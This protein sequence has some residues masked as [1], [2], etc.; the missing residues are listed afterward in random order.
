MKHLY[1]IAVAL[2]VL[3]SVSCKSDQDLIVGKW[4][5]VGYTYPEVLEFMKSGEFRRTHDWGPPQYGAKIRYTICTGTYELSKQRI[6]KWKAQCDDRTTSEQ[7]LFVATL[8]DDILSLEA[9][10]F[11]HFGTALQ[12]TF[13]K[14]R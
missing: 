6:L 1:L 12:G 7:N 8:T 14:T 2:L 5:Q 13:A 9:T 11:F 3:V 10:E 4:T